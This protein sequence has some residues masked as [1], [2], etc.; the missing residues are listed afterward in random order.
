MDPNDQLHDPDRAKIRH[1][2]AQIRASERRTRN[3]FRVIYAF[4]IYYCIVF[5]F[6]PSLTP[7]TIP[8]PVPGVTRCRLLCRLQRFG[9]WVSGPANDSGGMGGFEMGDFEMGD[10][11]KGGVDARLWEMT[12]VGRVTV[13]PRSTIMLKEL[14]DM[15]IKMLMEYQRAVRE[16][17]A[18]AGDATSR[19]EHRR[20]EY[21]DAWVERGYFDGVATADWELDETYRWGIDEEMGGERSYVPR[22]ARRYSPLPEPKTNVNRVTAATVG[23]TL[24]HGLKTTLMYLVF[25]IFGL[26][27]F[28]LLLVAT[29][30]DAGHENRAVNRRKK[31]EA[32]RLEEEKQE[33]EFRRTGGWMALP[34]PP[35]PKGLMTRTCEHL[36][37]RIYEPLSRFYTILQGFMVS[38][39]R[40]LFW[41]GGHVVR[42]VALG[43]AGWLLY[44]FLLFWTKE[45]YERENRVDWWLA[46]IIQAT[47]AYSVVVVPI[48]VILGFRLLVTVRQDDRRVETCELCAQP[49]SNDQLMHTDGRKLCH[50]HRQQ[51]EQRV[52]QE[53]RQR[54]E[55]EMRKRCEQ[56]ALTLPS[57]ER[58][59]AVPWA[60]LP[61]RPF[62]LELSH[63]Y[64]GDAERFLGSWQR[65]PKAPL[66]RQQDFGFSSVYHRRP[67]GGWKHSFAGT[68]TGK[69]RRD[70]FS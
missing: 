9:E 7:F 43:T 12:A 64:E 50:E 25:L 40:T 27:M 44:R 70:R 16:A 56:K 68:S 39:L 26:G 35:G 37:S 67:D 58:F 21:V 34:P 3:Y 48:A 6:F 54:E 17:L 61:Q 11:E 19:E 45:D 60:P 63:G 10:V 14:A 38:I 49:L 41:V 66:R 23:D 69:P 59:R 24:L 33:E 13:T 46:F 57:S 31:M 29:V 4:V 55:E 1:M 28:T 20:G 65:F 2:K 47:A 42:L 30:W 15:D 8:K 53:L 62:S 36:W 51:E 32:R 52:V 22:A 18:S 5:F